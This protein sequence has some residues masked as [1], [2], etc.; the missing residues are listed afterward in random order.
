MDELAGR[1]LT[2]FL[3]LRMIDTKMN[4]FIYGLVDPAEPKHVRYVGM[5][6]RAKRPYAHARNA[7]KLTAKRTYLLN[8]ISSIQSE[9]RD[10]I[11]LILEKFSELTARS[12]VGQI[13]KMYIASLRQIGHKLTNTAEGGHGGA[14]RTG[15]KHTE[16]TKVKM[17]GPKSD[18][19]RAR[20]SASAKKRVRFP[21]SE[22]SRAKSSATQKGRPGM[23]WTTTSRAKLSAT[24][25]GRKKSAETCAKLS[26]ALMGHATCPKTR[27]AVIA[28]NRRRKGVKKK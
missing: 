27:A 13:E 26:A 1:R 9:G 19:A 18:E 7:R 11:V 23:P 25:K 10:P 8:W 17:R 16:A 5:A 14:T 2:S 24:M 6:M 28:S 21:P 3:T 20:M 4:P 12:F 15:Q 22:A